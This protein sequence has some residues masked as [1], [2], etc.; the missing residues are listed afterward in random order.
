MTNERLIGSVKWYGGYNYNLDRENKFGF[1]ES[2]GIDFYVHE[3][4]LLCS[5]SDLKTGVWVS[6]QVNEDEKGKSALLVNLAESD[7]DSKVIEKL[8]NKEQVPLETRIQSCLRAPLEIAIALKPLLKK[9]FREYDNSFM[10]NEPVHFPKSWGNVDF[11][12]PLIDVIPK[13]N[14]HSLFDCIYPSIKACI[15]VLSESEDKVRVST[16]IYREMTED[17]KKL[18]SI[19]AGTGSSYELAKML[20]AR[21]AELS[22][23][24]FYKSIGK[25]INDI[26]IHQITG[27]SKGWIS[28]DL[29]VDASIPVDVKNARRTVNGNLF[30]EYT[31][32]AFKTDSLGNHV[33]VLGVLSPYLTLDESKNE[34]ND[35]YNFEKIIILG[36]TT[37]GAVQ[38]LQEEFSKRELTVEFGDSTRWPLWVFNNSLELFTEQKNAL[39]S[40]KDHFGKVDSEHWTYCKYKLIPVILGSGL[41]IPEYFKRDLLPWEIWYLEKISNQVKSKN[42]SLP[43]LYLFTFHHFIDAVTKLNAAELQGYNPS[44]YVKILFSSYASDTIFL[45]YTSVLSDS[46][47]P[48]CLIDP[49]GVIESL[50]STLG[51]LWENR[52]AA[53]LGSLKSFVL[54]GE[55]LLSAIDS[56]GRKV[57]V[58]AYC[59][60]F[61]EGKGKCGNSPLIIGKNKTCPTCHMLVCDKCGYC[62]N[63]CKNHH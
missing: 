24:S 4:Q 35:K 58:L 15:A 42:F 19:W 2:S 27:E 44:G 43:W 45:D 18:A 54:R 21:G 38:K 14:K 12:F 39:S 53:K 25:R 10:G 3:S 56:N 52:R 33:S 48:V 34:L 32:K 50:I 41:E 29:L 20:S 13:A 59:G 9:T 8:L 62:S 63:Q 55:G 60:G 31:V 28:H 36:E 1:L 51:T 17:D 40:F 5:P 47:R 37:K 22:A 23:A 26:A 6:F 11:S 30:V 7:T 16:Q 57:T 46:D 61:I 49:V